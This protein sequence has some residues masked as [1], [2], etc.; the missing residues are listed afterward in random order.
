M[1]HFLDIVAQDIFQKYGANMSD[2]VVVFPNKRAK[3]FFNAHLAQLTDKPIWTPAYMSITDFFQ[4]QTGLHVA[5]KLLL[6]CKL[7]EAYKQIMPQTDETIDDFYSW[8]EVLLADF[9]DI[10]K[11]LVDAEQLFKNIEY[12]HE[13]DNDEFL[14]DDQRQ[15]LKHFFNLVNDNNTELKRRFNDLWK[16]LYSIYKKF[17]AIL[18]EEKLTYEGAL[19]RQVVENKLTLNHSCYIFVG[20]NLLQ[21]AEQRLFQLVKAE[22]KAKFYWDIDSYYIHPNGQQP[23]HEAGVYIETYMEQFPN[24][25]D[26]DDES[27]FNNLVSNTDITYLAANTETAQAR[28]VGEWLRKQERIDAG[29][30]TAIVLCNEDLLPNI[31]HSIPPMVSNLNVTAGLRLSTL[32]IASLVNTLIDLRMS[33][34]ANRKTYM[35]RR[36]IQQLAYHPLAQYISPDI[37][38]IRTYLQEYNYPFIKIEN[39]SSDE[40]IQHLFRPFDERQPQGRQ[41]TEWMLHILETIGRNTAESDDILLKESIFKCFTVFQRL[42]TLIEQQ[43]LDF[44]L[45][46][47][48]RLAKQIIS[49]TKIP[50]HGE[51]AVGVQV[52]GLFETRNLDFDHLLVLSCNEGNLPRQHGAMS[53]IPYSLRKAFGLSTTEH[54]D[55][56]Y[57]YYFHRLLQRSKDI[58][59]TYNQATSETSK[60]EMS[61]YMLQLLIESPLTIKR[62]VISAGQTIYRRLPAKVQKTDETMAALHEKGKISP[63]AI[64][65][66][67][68]CPLSFY[69]QY[70]L[71]LRGDVTA[72][73]PTDNR[74][75]GNLF[76][77]AAR[78]I[79][80]QVLGMANGRPTTAQQY[81]DL[82]KHVNIDK[83]L[84]QA[85]E[86]Y[87]LMSH[88]NQAVKHDGGLNLIS[89]KVLINYL[90][91]LVDID[92]RHAP[93]NILEAEYPAEI[94]FQISVDGKIF[95][96]TI[97][98]TIDRI[99][100]PQALPDTIRIV[101]YK[102]GSPSIK[103][104]LKLENI[105]TSDG[106]DQHGDYFLQTFIYSLMVRHNKE[107][108]PRQLKVSPS[109]MFIRKFDADN[110][111]ATLFLNNEPVNDIADIEDE[112][113][114][115]LTDLLTEI[116]SPEGEFAPT[117]KTKRCETCDFRHLCQN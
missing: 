60:A 2:I 25:L 67:L 20:F 96:L 26:T 102:T 82:L 101:D 53:I 110:P 52:M 31:L 3:L 70:C 8:G 105:F 61:H 114:T 109:L 111:L 104:N 71:S 54:I 29:N 91:R 93:A 28:F 85:F 16:N 23:K 57:S 75:F 68:R 73:D 22:G 107:L 77:D 47:L 27:I 92:R 7:Y 33:M 13:L 115:R 48:F 41:F 50:F 42:S 106:I 5:D 46:T 35:P 78:N 49:R 108:N 100:C 59:L 24:E 38:Q 43:R 19:Y 30:R 56:L 97:G 18:K 89:R 34:V 80:R 9:D 113:V 36:M 74:L 90:K 99:D 116:Y 44:H 72:D 40:M 95:N 76:H 51:P 94:D 14:S 69:Y 10:D 64:G 65:K 84:D 87:K 81:A 55:S 15:A 112:L 86:Y 21:K 12:L 103:T 79:H 6:I 117:D 4:S 63:S 39:I 17:N 58:T 1:K 45:S 32:P 66:Y 62:Q 83:A 98:G 88:I 11:N 37:E